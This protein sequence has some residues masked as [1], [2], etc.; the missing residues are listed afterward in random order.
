MYLMIINGGTQVS[1]K[2]DS[3]LKS[4]LIAKNL[5]LG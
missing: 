4:D 2:R 3:E 5:M 1:D